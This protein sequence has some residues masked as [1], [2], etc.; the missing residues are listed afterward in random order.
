[1]SPWRVFLIA[2]SPAKLIESN[3]V[4]SLNRPSKL[5]DTSWIQPGKAHHIARFGESAIDL[6]GTSGIEY[7]VIEP[8]WAP[9]GNGNVPNLM[10]TTPEIDM[11]RDPRAS[12][13]AQRR[14]LVIDA[15][16]VRR[17]ADGGSVRAVRK[18]GRARSRDRRH[19]S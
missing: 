6:T 15:L 2:D 10:R 8:G 14:R 7:V 18:M 9:I 4:T 13:A 5:R 11:P 3:I 12:Q 19:E 16:A 17:I 1:M